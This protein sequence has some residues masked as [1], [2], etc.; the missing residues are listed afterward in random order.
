MA[1]SLNLMQ[2]RKNDHI[3]ICLEEAVDLGDAGFDA[4]G[5]KT[6]ALPEMALDDVCLEQ[7]FLGEKF[8][9]PIMIAGMTG[10]VEKAKIVNES[11][12]IAAERASIPFGIGS[13]KMMV[14]ERF[15]GDFFNIRNVAPKVFLVG[16][17]GAADLNAAISL[18]DVKRIV[19]ESGLNAIALHLNAL[20]ECVQPEGNA[21]F[22]NVL[23][24]I[25]RVV[26]ALDIPVVVKEVGAGIS[27]D[28]YRRLADTGVRAVD[29]GGRGG[30]SWSLIE[31]FRGSDEDKRLGELFSHWG[32]RTVDAVAACARAKCVCE[33]APEIVATGGIRDGVAV[34]KAVGLGATMC[35]VGLPFLRAVMNP[36]LG[37][38]PVESV[39]REIRYFE[40]S[41][42]IAMF[43][44]GV[45]NLNA[46]SRVVFAA[47]GC[48]SC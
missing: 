41:L 1:E 25:E 39:L 48:R 22:R 15:K 23:V 47:S 32:V 43:C 9:L 10:G 46:L 14:R 37:L 40:R 21:D 11:L 42:R 44:A 4:V 28:D 26:R 17:I 3:A 2:S 7:F 18:D 8:D 19:D 33:C 20:Q 38:S 6:T 34:A 35:G 12:A 24:A 16:N 36:T 29:V 5:L 27:A 13:Q 45:K 30:T 31:G